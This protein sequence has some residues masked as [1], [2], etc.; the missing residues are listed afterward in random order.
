MRRVRTVPILVRVV[1]PVAVAMLAAGVLAG[2]VASKPTPT[3]TPTATSSGTASAA[4]AGPAINLAGTAAQNQ[5]YFDSVNQK[6]IAAGGDLSGRPFI[7]NL[8]A[9]G[10][11]KVN[12]EV[13]PDRTAVDLAADNIQFSI[14][15]GTTCL[16]GQY[17]NV[18]YS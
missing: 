10:Y 9:A 13:T 16:I 18:G 7:D 3:Y 4:P 6:F 17:G 15:F 1:A 5:A 14:R 8:V 11:Q 12:M 2:C